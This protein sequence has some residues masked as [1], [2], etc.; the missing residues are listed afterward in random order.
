[1]EARCAGP[2]RRCPVVVE[3]TLQSARPHGAITCAQGIGE[4]CGGPA[5]LQRCPQRRE[6]VR[7]QPRGGVGLDQLSPC[8][9]WP[10]VAPDCRA[11][12][13]ARPPGCGEL[14]ITSA[15]RRSGLKAARFQATPPP[16]SWATSTSMRPPSDSISG[17]D[18]LHQVLGAI[19][20]QFGRRTRMLVAAQVGRHAPRAPAQREQQ[21]VPDERRLRKPVQQ[22]DALRRIGRAAGAARQRARR[23]AALCAKVSTCP[24]AQGL[25]GVVQA[26][27]RKRREQRDAD[28][29]LFGGQLAQ[30]LLRRAPARAD[31]SRRLSLSALVS[32]TSSWTSPLATRGAHV[33]EQLPVE[34]R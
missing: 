12:H 19:G 33:V 14:T 8:R 6:V 26:I 20:L 23:A 7:S 32:S 10:R 3:R 18:V 16:Q 17:V 28:V 2:Q 22:H 30:H 1:M 24:F 13:A 11:T 21:R 31:A 15:L 34:R 29:G 4:P 27:A 9:R 25:C 5:A